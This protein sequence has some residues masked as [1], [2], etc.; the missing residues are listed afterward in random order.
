M[1]ESMPG[2]TR[3]SAVRFG[4]L[5]GLGCV[6]DQG[7]TTRGPQTGDGVATNHASGSK[8]LQLEFRQGRQ[9]L[10]H[11][12]DVVHRV[13]MPLAVAQ[14]QKELALD[15]RE[16]AISSGYSSGAGIGRRT[17]RYPRPE[18]TERWAGHNE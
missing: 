16:P 7:L 18:T 13:G 9:A 1:E 12:A 8:V 2:G 15:L 14:R 3:A 6:S 4:V 17:A 5:L 11:L 10:G